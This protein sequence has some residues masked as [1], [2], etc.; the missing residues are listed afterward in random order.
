ML[1]RPD[2]TGL[3]EDG[4]VVFLSSDLP[5]DVLEVHQDLLGQFCLSLCEFLLVFE[6]VLL[7]FD[8]L[9]LV[10]LHS[11][12]EAGS[13]EGVLLFFDLVA[14]A[15]ECFLACVEFFLAFLEQTFQLVLGSTSLVGF[16]QRSL[17]VHYGD[18]DLGVDAGG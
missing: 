15:L 4:R 10:F 16:H 6:K 8:E 7:Q 11:S 17:Q 5:D 9:F 12:L 13:V 14:H 2:H 1:W 18:A 3:F